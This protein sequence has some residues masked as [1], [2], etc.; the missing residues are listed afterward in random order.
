[1]ATICIPQALQPN[2]RF[3]GWF[4]SF[5]DQATLD[6]LQKTS[7]GYASEKMEGYP[8]EESMERIKDRIGRK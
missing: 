2:R 5:C 8:V 6:S 7:E 4:F 1:M 3:P